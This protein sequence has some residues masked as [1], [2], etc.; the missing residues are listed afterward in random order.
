MSQAQKSVLKGMTILSIVGIISKLIGALHRIP[1]A[2]I[3]GEQG[4]GMYQLVF[5]TYNMLLAIS[6][7]GLPVAI[8]RMVSFYLAK[9]DVRNAKKIF[10]LSLYFL[11]IVGLFATLLM[12]VFSPQLA[13]RTG[14]VQT[15]MGFITIAPSLLLVC[16]LSA[17]RGYLQGQQNMTPTAISQL[18]EQV[19]KV[20]LALPLAYFGSKI[21]IAMAAAFVLL[22]TSLA[23]ACAL[24]YIYFSYRKNKKI[25]NSYHQN[26]NSP[27]EK[28]GELLKKVLS[29]AIP[30]TLAGCI[31]PISGFI[32]SGLLLN[33]LIDA[34]IPSGEA[35]A[36][37][38]RYSG[39]VITLIN[40]PSAFA[41]A[42]AM[43]LVPSISAGIAKNNLEQ[44]HA[45][46]TWGLRYAFLI[47]L[48]CS[49]GMSILSKEILSF[50]YNF[51]S[52]ESLSQ[53][54]NLLSLSAL[55]IV[56]F[57][58][59]QA[60]SGILQG[61]K[62][63]KIPMYTLLAGV[64]VK[65]TLN[66]ILIGQPNIYIFGAPIASLACYTISLL[67]NIYF[68]RKELPFALPYK[69]ILGKPLMA[70]AIMGVG[71]YGLQ[72]LLPKGRIFTLLLIV[73]GVIL[74]IIGA[75]LT[76]AIEKNEYMRLIKKFKK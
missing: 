28:N 44:V 30:I 39:Y 15:K 62:K 73:V 8:S 66:Y 75:V 26:L 17:Y 5:P 36:M 10:K 31:V 22:G 41:A 65:I 54:A 45:R 24:L 63:Q 9:D 38:G 14:D 52:E 2:W 72:Q 7:A 57:T 49:I 74:Y 58:G 48:P 67:P 13:E 53:T 16:V 56:L 33:R 71:I 29:M 42:L 19:G 35:L 6:S 68:V 61:M 4:M 60:T 18:I 34:G 43:N 1:L 70:T 76:G 27:L 32:D 12:I 23:E 21:S 3:I 51:S 11:A 46:S 50:V 55:T 69:N 47:G 59:V 37:Y 40:V 25:V 64:I 20:L